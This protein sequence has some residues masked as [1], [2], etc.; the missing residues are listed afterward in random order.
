MKKLM[1]SM[2][3]VTDNFLNNDALSWK[4]Q[5]PYYEIYQQLGLAWQY[6]AEHCGHGDGYKKTKD[7]KRACKICGQ[8]RLHRP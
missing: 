5:K 6:L 3:F 2:D 8:G 4:K 1:R 7:G